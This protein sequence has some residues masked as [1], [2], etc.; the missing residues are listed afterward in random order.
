VDLDEFYVAL[1]GL[2]QADIPVDN[3]GQFTSE[4]FFVADARLGVE[5]L[6][7]G[8]L[9][10]SP[11]VAVQNVFDAWYNSSVIVNAFGKRFYEPGPGRTFLLGLGITWGN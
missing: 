3:G 8:S 5:N 9:E 10:A 4:S 11:F 6:V 7:L 1:R 2:F